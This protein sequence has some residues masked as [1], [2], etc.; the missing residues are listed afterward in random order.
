MYKSKKKEK[1]KKKKKTYK[2]ESFKYLFQMVEDIIL[3]IINNNL[4]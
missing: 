2:Y 3:I 1:K 4:Y